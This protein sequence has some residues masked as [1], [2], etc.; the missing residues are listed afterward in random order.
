[1]D[2]FQEGLEGQDRR[3]NGEAWKPSVYVTVPNT[4]WIHKLVTVVLLKLQGDPRYAKTIF[5]PT[6]VPLENNQHHIINDF[7]KRHDEF[8]L[9]ID[10]DNPPMNNPLDLVELDK[11]VIGCPTPIWHFTDKP[12]ER[13]IYWGGYDYVEAEDGY[14]EHEPKDGLQRVDAISGG[15]MLIHRRVLSHPDMR[16]GP[17]VRKLNPDGTVHKGN[18][19]SFCERA[20]AAGF[21]IWAHYD[22][23]CMHFNELELNEVVRAFQAWSDGG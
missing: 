8:W 23:P 16:R 1:M 21:E 9:S 19:I 7:L 10:A 6:D 5:L 12:K 13:P 11:D 3:L 22:Y 14:K 18:D 4:G 20:R 17:F 15:C 2:G